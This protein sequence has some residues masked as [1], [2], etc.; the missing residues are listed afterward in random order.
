MASYKG[1]DKLPV[2]GG[3]LVVRPS[4]RDFSNLIETAMTTEFAKGSGWNRSRIGWCWGGMTVQG[5][6]P[7][8]YNRVTAPNRTQVLD[9]CVYNTMADTPD[10]M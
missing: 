8:Y 9:R 6:L 4:E 1:E 7:Y 2:Q 10:C 5:L 3:F